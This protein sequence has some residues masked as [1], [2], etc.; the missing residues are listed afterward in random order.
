MESGGWGVKEIQR[1]FR[2]WLY[3]VISFLSSFCQ[4]YILL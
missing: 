3:V 2:V 4:F 1:V